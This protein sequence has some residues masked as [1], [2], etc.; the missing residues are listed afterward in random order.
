MKNIHGRGIYESPTVTLFV[1]NEDV[2]QV[3]R[4]GDGDIGG[5]DIFEPSTGVWF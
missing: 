4:F 1:T 5:W 2:L 3:S